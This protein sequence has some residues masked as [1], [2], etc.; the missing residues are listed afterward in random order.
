MFLINHALKLKHK[1]SH[2]KL[3]RGT[4]HHPIQYTSFSFKRENIVPQWE[5]KLNSAPAAAK[6]RHVQGHAL[7]VNIVTVWQFHYYCRKQESKDRIKWKYHKPVCPY[8]V[9]NI[10]WNDGVQ[11]VF[12]SIVV[13]ISYFIWKVVKMDVCKQHILFVSL[14]WPCKTKQ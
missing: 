6:T 13:K 14:L 11:A 12:S 5:C 3:N 4:G 1:P 2:L 8:S 9:Q 10:G 7:K